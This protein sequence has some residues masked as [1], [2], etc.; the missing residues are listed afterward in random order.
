MRTKKQRIISFLM[1]FLLI[2]TFAFINPLTIQKSEAFAFAIPAL[3]PAM[4]RIITGVL[5]SAGYIIHEGTTASSDYDTALMDM[6]KVIYQTLDNVQKILLGALSIVDN[7]VEVPTALY[8]SIVNN[9]KKVIKPDTITSLSE[10]N[11]TTKYI[12]LE[13]DN[14]SYPD[15]I[16]PIYYNDSSKSG[17]GM[18]DAGTF[19]T[20]KVDLREAQPFFIYEG[21]GS[22]S[23]EW[24]I[25]GVKYFW[26]DFANHNL[27]VLDIEGFDTLIFLTPDLSPYKLQQAGSSAN[28]YYIKYEF[29]SNGDNFRSFEWSSNNS[30][31]GYSPV[32]FISLDIS[33]VPN[34]NNCIIYSYFLYRSSNSTTLKTITDVYDKQTGEFQLQIIRDINGYSI[35]QQLFK[36]ITTTPYSYDLD[37]VPSETIAPPVTNTTG[38]NVITLPSTLSGT[39]GATST[40]VN[41]PISDIPDSGTET[42]DRIDTNVGELV[43]GGTLGEQVNTNIGTVE[44]LHSELTEQ[45]NF[46]AVFDTI[47]QYISALDISS[48]TWFPV[49]VASFLV[50]FLPVISLG[51]IL[52]FIDRVLNGGA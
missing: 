13:P 46:G 2:F 37:L 26:N 8:N 33:N 19:T 9:A 48:V 24:D 45:V 25:Q 28:P 11:I 50:P 1:A 49:A 7:V 15:L 27:P 39:I 16:A 40:D 51:I 20:R 12:T 31:G 41:I 4:G 30:S 44:G 34:I 23:T 42:I 21:T 5:V 10:Q 6:S 3:T 38:D 22:S 14:I 17:T 47:A 18:T 36:K 35:S 29:L 43:T 32:P 52:F